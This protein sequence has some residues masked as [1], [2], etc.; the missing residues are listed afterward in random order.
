M[1]SG[2]AAQ[3]TVFLPNAGAEDPNIVVS[4]VGVGNDGRTT[5]VAAVTTTTD[6]DIVE[7]SK[8]TP[9]SYGAFI[10]RTPLQP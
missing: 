3:E 4:V 10:D 6:T 5:Y 9:L 7:P 1:E 2:A 8:T